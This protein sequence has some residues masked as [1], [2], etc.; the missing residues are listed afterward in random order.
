ML[1]NLTSHGSIAWSRYWKQT[2]NSHSRGGEMWPVIRPYAFCH[3]RVREDGVRAI[4]ELVVMPALRRQGLAT[5]LVSAMSLPVEVR[6]APTDVGARAFLAAMRFQP[7]H[8]LKS[9]R[10]HVIVYRLG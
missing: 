8:T 10:G 7:T 6:V 2:A 1:L 5:Q 9:K 4:D 3:Y